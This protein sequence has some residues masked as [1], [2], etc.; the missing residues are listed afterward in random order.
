MRIAFEPKPYEPRGHILYPTTAEGILLAHQV[1]PML[2]H[3]TNQAL[4]EDGH[5][6]IALNPEIGHVLMGYEDLGYAYSWPLSEGRLPIPTGTASHLATT[7]KTST[8]GRPEHRTDRDATLHPQDV[9]VHRLLRSGYQSR[10]H[11]D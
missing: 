7:I 5:A 10:A 4:L 1:E 6:L 3:P 11:A 9:W 2:T 8:W